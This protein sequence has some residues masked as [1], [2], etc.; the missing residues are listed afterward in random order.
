MKKFLIY[1]FVSIIIL[2]SSLIFFLSYY[3]YQTDR[4]NKIIQSEIKNSKK[5]INLAFDEISILLD[6]KNLTL[7]VKFINPEVEYNSLKIPLEILRANISILSLIKNEISIK[8]VNAETKFLEIDL[9][10]NYVSQIKIDKVYKNYIKEIDTSKIKLKSGFSFDNAFS[11]KDFT[12]N[13]IVKDTNIGS[14]TKYKLSDLNLNFLY[15]NEIIKIYNLF[16][17]SD[18]I[19]IENGKIDILNNKGTTNLK[20]NSKIIFQSNQETLPIINKKFNKGDTFTIKSD[21]SIKKNKKI[22]I[23][24]LIFSNDN[25]E[26]VLKNFILNKNLEILDFK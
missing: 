22:H 23:Q 15:K 25:N 5:G 6:I 8:N 9:I 7:F 4:F 10:K 26:V 18:Y 21:L 11:V 13:G 12:L 2:F 3:G 1:F 14:N 16:A 19:N 17:K 24:K 20:L